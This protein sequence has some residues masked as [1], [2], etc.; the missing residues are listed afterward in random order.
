MPVPGDS[1]AF[2]VVVRA[3]VSELFGVVR[4]RLSSTEGLGNG[5]HVGYS[6][7]RRCCC[8]VRFICFWRIC[9]TSCGET[10]CAAALSSLASPGFLNTLATCRGCVFLFRS[11]NFGCFSGSSI[12]GKLIGTTKFPVLR[13]P[14]NG[15]NPV[16][17]LGITRLE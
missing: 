9:F 16:I 5:Q 15:S 3:R 12:Y 8:S 4:P 1:V 10:F 17:S 14:C 11:M 6:K 7:N 13:Y 2:G